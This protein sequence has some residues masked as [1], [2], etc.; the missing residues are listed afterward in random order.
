MAHG[1]LG[2]YVLHDLWD[3]MCCVTFD[4]LCISIS[5]QCNCI[6]VDVLLF[7]AV[8]IPIWVLHFY[9][10]RLGYMGLSFLS[11]DAGR[12]LSITIY[13]NFLLKPSHFYSTVG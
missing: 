12:R 9:Q 4:A 3:T 5:M 11:A 1:P 2:Q 6:G 13:D 8:V 7:D 10:P